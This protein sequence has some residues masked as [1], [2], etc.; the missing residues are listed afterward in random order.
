[1][2]I[3]NSKPRSQGSLLPELRR[4]K[5]QTF[6]SATISEAYTLLK[7]FPPQKSTLICST[8]RH[9]HTTFSHK[10]ADSFVPNLIL[11]RSY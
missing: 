2:F 9:V 3:L 8:L 7:A 1:M 6:D 11:K 5:R 10:N 4:E